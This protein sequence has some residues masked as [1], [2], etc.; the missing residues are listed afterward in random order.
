MDN[1]FNYNTGNT[2]FN[3][4]DNTNSVPQY[5]NPYSYD[6]QSSYGS[7]DH[8]KYDSHSSC[9]SGDHGKYDSHS[10]HGIGGDH[11]KYDS[12]ISHSHNSYQVGIDDCRNTA[13]Q[14][15]SSR[16]PHRG[17][18]WFVELGH[19]GNTSVQGGCRPVLI[20]S[21]DEGNHHADTICVLPMTTRLK[22]GYLPSHVEISQENLA[23]RDY[24]RHLEPSMILAEQI[25]TISKSALRSYLGIIGDRKKLEEINR[26]VREQ[27]NV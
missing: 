3:N 20:I 17:E 12:H 15:R 14:G 1:N 27:L 8:G 11:D 26:A 6:S 22:K 21:N 25:T 24:G 10:S 18:V 4:Q 9:G 13:W 2:D 23:Y 7:G 5:N 16:S 19:H